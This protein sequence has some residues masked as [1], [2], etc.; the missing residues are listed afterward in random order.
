MQISENVRRRTRILS[1]YRA[2]AFFSTMCKMVMSKSNGS[3]WR[4]TLGVVSWCDG[5][6]T[7]SLRA[8][9]IV[10]CLHCVV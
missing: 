4:R 10:S 9:R 8:S 7:Q 3:N 1:R 6:L 5:A 2:R